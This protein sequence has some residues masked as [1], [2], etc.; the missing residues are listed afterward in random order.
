MGSQQ[1]DR[2]A[3]TAKE[4]AQANHI[5]DAEKSMP[6]ED[7]GQVRDYTGAARKTDPEEI[8]LVSKLDWCIMVSF[9]SI[10]AIKL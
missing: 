9:N 10:C 8:R 1:H 5:S 4:F 3:D 7:D 6:L 2:Q